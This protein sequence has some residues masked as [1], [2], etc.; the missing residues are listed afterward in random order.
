MHSNINDQD[1]E[2]GLMQ[3][4]TIFGLTKLFFYAD[5]QKK[6]SVLPHMCQ[7]NSSNPQCSWE[8]TGI[9]KEENSGEYF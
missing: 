7:R 9:F 2:E 6:L 8:H 3:T 4:Q 5:P 1:V